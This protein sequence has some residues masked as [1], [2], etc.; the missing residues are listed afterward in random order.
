[1]VKGLKVKGCKLFRQEEC[2]QSTTFWTQFVLFIVGTD[3]DSTHGSLFV[4]YV[5]AF[6]DSS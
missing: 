5:F 4:A 3:C 1:M 2:D 6:L